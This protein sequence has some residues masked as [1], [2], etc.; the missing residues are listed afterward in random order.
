MHMSLNIKPHSPSHSP[1]LLSTFNTPDVQ[2]HVL[3]LCCIGQPGFQLNIPLSFLL[4]NL[5]TPEM[6]TSP[7]VVVQAK[8]ARLFSNIMLGAYVPNMW[9]PSKKAGSYS[10]RKEMTCETFLNLMLLYSC[11]VQFLS[12][13][14]ALYSVCVLGST[15][16]R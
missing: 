15:G 6:I 10:D 14:F 5:S 7:Y 1:F 13:F 9:W 16:I 4:S 3:H 2:L 8:G 11:C 12:L